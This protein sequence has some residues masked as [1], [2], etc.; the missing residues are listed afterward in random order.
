MIEN[1][2]LKWLPKF[3]ELQS[4]LNA[5]LR[6]AAQDG[7]KPLIRI[8]EDEVLMGTNVQSVEI[9]LALGK[10]IPSVGIGGDDELVV[11]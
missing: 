3:V 1:K 11:E 6:A 9:S 4:E 2:T 8:H 7:V 10:I 5:L